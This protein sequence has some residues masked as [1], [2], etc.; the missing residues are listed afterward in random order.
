MFEFIDKNG[1]ISANSA[2]L[3]VIDKY[4]KV[5]EVST[6][7]GGS[8]TGPAGGDLSGTYPNPSVVWNNGVPTYNLLYYPLSSNPAGYLTGITSSDVTTA[9]GYTPVTNARIL[10]INGVSYDLTADR[11]WTVTGSSPLTTKGDLYTFSTVNARL[12]VGLD[13]QVLIADSTTATGLKW[14]S[15]TAPTPTGYYAQYQ[16]VLTQTIAVINTG[17]PIK[18][19]TLDLS[20]GVTVV[21]DS[22]ITF[23][24]TG[25]YNLQFSIQLQNADTQEHDVTIWLRK[26]GVDVVGSAGFVAVIAKHG[27]VNG[28]VLPSW[29]YLLD[30]I[31]GEYYE[32]VWS[33]TSTQVTMQFYPAGSPPPSTASAIFTVTQQAGIMAGTGITALNSLTGS[34]QTMVVGTGATNL[35]IVSSG[36]THTFNLLFNIRRNANNSTNNNINYCGYAPDGSAESAT[37]WTITR[38][39][40]SASGAI[41]VGTATNVAW[42][43]RESVIYT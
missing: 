17:Y 25:I 4:G 32:L 39:T 26:N 12:P 34:V 42:T 15:N 21:S 19:R 28:H 27:G 18:F 1:N 35:N 43:N 36:S 7:G 23:A 10:T 9:L 8:P 33:A 5:K 11:S 6:G 38:L 3:V 14:G 31:A 30:V 24:N 22:R 40:I 20:N 2:K 41:T 29:N 16:D 37:V 13:T